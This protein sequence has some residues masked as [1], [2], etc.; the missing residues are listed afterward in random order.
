MDLVALLI[1]IIISTI[2]LAPVLW[3]AGRA[4]VGGDKAKFFD[5]IWIIVFTVIMYKIAVFKLKRRM[6][7]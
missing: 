6:F 2:I 5:A 1:Q 4:L 7:V 3:L